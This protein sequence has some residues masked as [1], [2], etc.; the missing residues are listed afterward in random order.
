[1]TVNKMS[2]ITNAKITKQMEDCFDEARR[3][4][5]LKHKGDSYFTH[6][7]TETA[8]TLFRSTYGDEQDE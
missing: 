6:D 4:L 2:E 7:L 3:I 1:M 5:D 8:L